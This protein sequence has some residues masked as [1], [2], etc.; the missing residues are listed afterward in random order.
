MGILFDSDN[1]P[2]SIL[3]TENETAAQQDAR[4]A[5]AETAALSSTTLLVA[6]S[7]A[8]GTASGTAGVGGNASFDKS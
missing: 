5:Q 8:G 6:N 2:F 3:Y 7:G 1:V 4:Y